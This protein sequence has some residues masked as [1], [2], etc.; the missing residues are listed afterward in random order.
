MKSYGKFGEYSHCRLEVHSINRRQRSKQTKPVCLIDVTYV[1]MKINGD[2]FGNYMVFF[3][4]KELQLSSK[5]MISVGI[6]N[7]R[8]LIAVYKAN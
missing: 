6:K 2:F 5:M 7:D 3:H 1:F 8:D 4:V